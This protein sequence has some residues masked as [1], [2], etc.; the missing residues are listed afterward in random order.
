MSVDMLPC[1]SG[2]WRVLRGVVV[3]ATLIAAGS[4]VGVSPASISIYIA[5]CI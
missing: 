1:A 4:C 5:A 3:A 2:R